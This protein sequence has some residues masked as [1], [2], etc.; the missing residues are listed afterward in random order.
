MDEE[1]KKMLEQNLKLSSE[2]YKQTKYIKNYVFWAQIAGVVKI[3]LIVV[4]LV[5]GIIYLPPL[6]KGAFDQY[7]DL[8]GIQPEAAAGIDLKNFDMNKI[9]S[10]LGK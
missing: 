7:K 1:I 6:L 9:N 8:L 5:I 3:L 4:P 10:L 2:I